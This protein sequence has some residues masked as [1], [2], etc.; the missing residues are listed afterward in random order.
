MFLGH[1]IT[2]DGVGLNDDKVSALT[3][4]PVPTD[5]KK[6]HSLL[7]DLSYY[8]KFLPNMARRMRPVKALLKKGARFDFTPEIVKVVCA[9]PVELASPLILVFPVWDA[10]IDKFNSLFLHYDASTDGLGDTLEQEQ[11]DALSAP[12]STLAE[13]HPTASG[14]GPP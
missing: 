5:I 1:V 6:L 11:P 12:W 8:R 14:S 3:R 13:P 2:Q 7:G 10:G 9:L 4:M